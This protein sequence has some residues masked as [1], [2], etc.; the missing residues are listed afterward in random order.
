[1]TKLELATSAQPGMP[2]LDDNAVASDPHGTLAHWREQT[3]VVALRDGRILVL[4]ATEVMALV[5]D[6]RTVQ[7]P[8]AAYARYQ[9]VP[10][11]RARAFLERTMLLSNHGDHARRR[12]PFARSFAF[13]AMRAKRPLMRQVARSVVADMPRGVPFDLVETVAARIPAELTATLLGLPV[14]DAGWFGAQVYRLSRTL[15]TNYPLKL[16]DEIEAAAVALEGY[17]AEALVA[18]R[19]APR[20]DLLTAFS[21][22]IDE[23][24][25]DDAVGQL[26]TLVL[27][28]SDTTRFGI[29]AMVD[30]LLR[31]GAWAEVGADR[32]LLEGAVAEAL[33]FEPPVGALPRLTVERLEIGE[34]E[35]LPGRLVIL[36]TFSAMRDAA[37]FSDPDR[38]D[39]RRSDHPKL[40]L[41]F[42]GGVH[43]C[44]G[45]MLARLEMAEA[46]DALLDAAP[47][48]EVLEP[49]RFLGI[50]G[51]RGI[52]PM[53]VQAG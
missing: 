27:A 14:A 49:S 53:I 4:R 44:L 43:R 31:H 51:I 16:H 1:M 23:L 25:E 40:H 28:G 47:K 46:L 34:H 33:R 17:L 39:I 10:Q 2:L 48:L 36:S 7:V 30:L 29:A 9:Q 22:C 38:F 32:G 19:R 20:D 11:G 41:V 26:M 37:V 45:E 15:S 3:P 50:G 18:R 42:G 12:A 6:P 35:V 24:G 8:G 13:P 52:T 21:G 5:T